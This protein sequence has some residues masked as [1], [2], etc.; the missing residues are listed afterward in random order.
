MPASN[1]PYLDH[2]YDHL[3]IDMAQTLLKKEMR[4]L[5]LGLDTADWV[6][7]D[8]SIT[9]WALDP[10]RYH[11]EQ[12]G[13][14]DFWDGFAAVLESIKLKPEFTAWITAENVRWSRANIPVRQIQMTSFLEQLHQIPE[15]QPRN[16]VSIAEIAV[17]LANA[18]DIHEQQKQLNDLHS[19]DPGQDAYPIIARQIGPELYAVLDGN[20]RSLRAL[21]QERDTIDAWVGTLEGPRLV[22]Y[23]VPVNDM[24]QLAKVFKNAEDSRD[25]HLQQAVAEVLR[26]HFTASVVAE[27]IYLNRIGNQSA[28][29]D[30]LYRACKQK[31][32]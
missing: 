1:R 13:P 19:T 17:L 11:L 22:N 10:K 25:K 9:G 4:K 14:R 24:T 5:F 29:A 26:S 18:P 3:R 28:V 21:L 27:Q 20:R 15:L 16:D 31:R 2:I 23:W 12:D 30:R 32:E 7:V 6:A 8:K